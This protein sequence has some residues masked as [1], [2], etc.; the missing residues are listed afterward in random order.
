[1]HGESSAV[2]LRATVLSA[3]VLM[4]AALVAPVQAAATRQ[5]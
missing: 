4:I 2:K 1:M 5:R 3:A